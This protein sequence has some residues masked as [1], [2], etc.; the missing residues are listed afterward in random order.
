MYLRKGQK[1]FNKGELVFYKSIGVAEVTDITTLD[2]S[3]EK[4]QKYYVMESVFK[5]GIN[6]VPVSDDIEDIREIISKEQAEEFVEMIPEIT[7]EPILD[8]KSR[9]MTASYENSISS[10][11]PLE[12]IKL[13]VSIEAKR[14]QV[15]EEGKNFG[16]IDDNF[17]KKAKDMMYEEFAAALDIK[18][19]EVP[20]YIEKKVGYTFTQ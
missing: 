19:D 12:I 3:L 5:N 16:A 8:M 15:L 1:L 4:D 18:K 11:D 9:Q 20:D 17:L 2:F 13:A 6:Y 7:P 14:K 10:G